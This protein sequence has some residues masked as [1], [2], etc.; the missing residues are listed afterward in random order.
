MSTDYIAVQLFNFIHYV[1]E[2]D[3]VVQPLNGMGV[4]SGAN[5][6]PESTGAA[7]FSEF[8]R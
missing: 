6:C 5:N 7:I 3:Y 4:G 8:W 2:G 1:F